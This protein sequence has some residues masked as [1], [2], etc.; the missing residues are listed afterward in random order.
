M[1]RLVSE[2]ENT[3]RKLRQVPQIP[4]MGRFSNPA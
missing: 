3:V 4:E 2:R 1:M